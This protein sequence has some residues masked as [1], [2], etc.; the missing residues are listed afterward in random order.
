MRI[1]SMKTLF[2]MF[3]ILLFVLSPL[4]AAG[5]NQGHDN[6]H[7]NI[8][9][10]TSMKNDIKDINNHLK[11]T[12]MSKYKTKNNTKNQLSWSSWDGDTV[13][14]FVANVD[15]GQQPI[16]H[17]K[18]NFKPNSILS[19]RMIDWFNVTVTGVDL[20][21]MN[22]SKKYDKVTAYDRDVWNSLKLDED[23]MPGKYKATIKE[24]FNGNPNNYTYF[25]VRKLDIVDDMKPRIEINSEN[26]PVFNFTRPKTKYDLTGNVTIYSSHLSKQY[27]IPI[28][29]YEGR[30]NYI[31]NET[32]KPDPDIDYWVRADYSGNIIY[33]GWRIFFRVKYK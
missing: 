15:Y 7:A 6:T 10:S 2:G 9:N 22:Y 11:N 20:E 1:L 12:N 16:L 23:L 33:K 17:W 28:P 27:V 18:W 5:L 30:I 19:S 4:N 29:K 25:V 3:I 24:W 8:N 13:D 31:V 32:V 21:N 14:I 26:K